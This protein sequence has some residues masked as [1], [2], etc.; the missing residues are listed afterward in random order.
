MGSMGKPLALCKN[1]YSFPIE[2]NPR[3]AAI[4]ICEIVKITKMIHVFPHMDVMCVIF[5]V[6]FIE[7]SLSCLYFIGK[8]KK[9][10]YFQNN[11]L[12]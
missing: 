9:E 7:K 8:H 6:C 4:R 10:I 1:F 2:S 3:T 12:F 11:T 5:T